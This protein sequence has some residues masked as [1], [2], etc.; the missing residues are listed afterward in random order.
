MSEEKKEPKDISVPL[1][2]ETFKALKNLYD[3]WDEL[4]MRNTRLDQEKIGILAAL[5]R[6]DQ[7]I[8]G[9]F[10]TISVDYNISPH[11]Q[12]SVDPHTRKIVV[13]GETE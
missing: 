6:L 5:K 2:E 3:A 1:D 4:S 7:E 13:L 12:I 9:L 10:Q 8:L 11:A